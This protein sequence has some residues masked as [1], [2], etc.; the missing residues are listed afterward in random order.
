MVVRPNTGVVLARL[1]PASLEPISRE[2]HIGE[3]HDAWALS[4]DGSQ[5]AV[6]MSAPGGEKRIGILIV[7]LDRM[8]VVQRVAT[9]IAA[10]AVGWLAPRLLVGALQRGGTVLVDPVTGTIVRR[11]PHLSDPQGAARTRDSFALLFP[12]P[13]QLAVVD[14]Q[15][16]LRTVVLERIRLAFRNVQ[17]D[18]AGLAVT[19]DGAQ[20][21]VVAPDGQIADVDLRTMRVSYHRVEALHG[22]PE[23][24][25]SWRQR[26]ALWLGD[27]RLLVFGRDDFRVASGDGFAGVAA[28]ATL[29]DTRTWKTCLLDARASGAEFAAGRVLSYGRGVPTSRGLRAYTVEGRRAFHL[30]DAEA[31]WDVNVLGGWAYTQTPRA[32]H[33]VDARSGKVIREIAPPVELVDVITEQQ[34]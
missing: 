5:L 9:G 8:K 31:V 33:V 23:Q 34:R 15:G 30:L 20:A 16:E 28:G 4:P 26:R 32:V 1:D 25:P 24:E 13:V 21:Y 6:G 22:A 2:V 27:G 11:W 29:V 12:N 10:E 18:E 3:Y 7:D 14:S 17:S 19:F